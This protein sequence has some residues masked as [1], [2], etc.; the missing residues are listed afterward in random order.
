MTQIDVSRAQSIAERAGLKPAKVRGTDVIQFTRRPGKRFEPI[1][2]NDFAHD[3]ET[4]G[5]HVYE[6]SGWLKIMK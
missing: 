2:W 4:R 6:S 1:S 3:L 5:L